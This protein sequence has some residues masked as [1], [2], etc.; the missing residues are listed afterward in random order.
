VSE[1]NFG[2]MVHIVN[3]GSKKEARTIAEKE[4]A[5]EYADI[6]VVDTLKAGCVFSSG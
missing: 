4:G 2:K 5:W 6:Q 1:T 3:A